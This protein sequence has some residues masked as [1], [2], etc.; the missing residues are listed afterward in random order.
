MI[1]SIK[2]V[3][4]C[5][6]LSFRPLFNGFLKLGQKYKNVFVGFLV[7]MRS[8]EFAF[9]TFIQLIVSQ[10]INCLS[11]CTKI[12]QELCQNVKKFLKSHYLKTNYQME[13]RG[14]NSPRSHN[15]Y[16]I[17]TPQNQK[18]ANTNEESLPQRRWSHPPFSLFC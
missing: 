4:Q 9:K 5:F 14:S 13:M 7:Q 2:L 11:F 12:I 18:K 3:F 8:L 17:L 15:T 16:E 1:N 10:L 6:Y